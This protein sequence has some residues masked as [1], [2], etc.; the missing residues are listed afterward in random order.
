MQIQKIDKENVNLRLS[1]QEL[2][3]ISDAF[4]THHYRGK[5]GDSKDMENQIKHY[6]LN[7]YMEDHLR[8]F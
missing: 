1:I 6:L 2:Q 5:G 8:Y 3:H 7:Q 4:A